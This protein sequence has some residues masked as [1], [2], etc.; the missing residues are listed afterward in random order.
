MT[1]D[2]FFAEAKRL[3]LKATPEFVAAL[4]ER[5]TELAKDPEFVADCLSRL[6]KSSPQLIAGPFPTRCPW[7]EFK[8][9][10]DL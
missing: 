8:L 2:Q 9:S 3:D 7:D 6:A 10:K 5:S 1:L 4:A